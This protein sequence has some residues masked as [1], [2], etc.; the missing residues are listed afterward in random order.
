MEA[1]EH[2]LIIDETQ[3]HRCCSRDWTC[4]GKTDACEKDGNNQES[5]DVVK[6]KC[7]TDMQR[8]SA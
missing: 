1:L 4:G 7:V 2:D 8:G 6:P 3:S 5:H